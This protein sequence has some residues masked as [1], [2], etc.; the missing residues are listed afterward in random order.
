MTH[1]HGAVSAVH[2]KIFKC[3]NGKSERIF[4]L[5]DMH[6]CLETVWLVWLCLFIQAILMNKLTNSAADMFLDVFYFLFIFFLAE[7]P[8]VSASSVSI[9]E[10]WMISV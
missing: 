6:S 10:Y 2:I 3:G 4:L 8:F 7:F 5:V 1:R 9:F